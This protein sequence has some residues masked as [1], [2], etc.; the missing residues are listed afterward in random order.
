M[1]IEIPA[2]LW[3]DLRT[4]AAKH[5]KPTTD[6]ILGLLLGICEEYEPLIAFE[7]LKSAAKALDEVISKG[8]K[9][10][11]QFQGIKELIK[12]FTIE[13]SEENKFRRM[14]DE[15]DSDE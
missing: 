6:F 5:N 2:P 13:E 12:P 1:Q 14:F 3:G 9:H 7:E 15:E 11:D 8:G 10:T 4:L